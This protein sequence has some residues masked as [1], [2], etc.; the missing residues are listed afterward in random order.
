MRTHDI[1]SALFKALLESTHSLTTSALISVH[2][3]GEWMDHA[4]TDP[5]LN[6]CDAVGWLSAWP[7]ML[8]KRVWMLCFSVSGYLPP[9]FVAKRVLVLRCFALNSGLFHRVHSI[10]TTKWS[11]SRRKLLGE[12]QETLNLVI[13]MISITFYVRSNISFFIARRALLDAIS[14]VIGS[15]RDSVGVGAI[16]GGVCA[17]NGLMAQLNLKKDNFPFLIRL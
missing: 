14:T 4:L 12:G 17:I 8:R 1:Y 11:D 9:Y 6:A 10:T 5:I 7:E 3:E 15:H 13:I 2:D 16:I